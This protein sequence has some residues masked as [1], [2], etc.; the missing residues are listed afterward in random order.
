MIGGRM[1]LWGRKFTS[2]DYD[3]L[4]RRVDE[5]TRRRKQF[6]AETRERM[7][8]MTAFV[9]HHC[10]GLV[11]DEYHVQRRLDPGSAGLGD[12]R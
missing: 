7:E 2:F 11:R 10:V 4:R 5:S 12:D 6:N 8:A 9:S 1:V 3:G